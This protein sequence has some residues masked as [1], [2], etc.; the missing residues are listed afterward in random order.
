VAAGGEDLRRPSGR[1][2][3]RRR[4]GHEIGGCGVLVG[5]RLGK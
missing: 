5:G 2:G 4:R 3:H 1:P